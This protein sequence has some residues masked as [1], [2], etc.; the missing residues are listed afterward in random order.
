MTTGLTILRQ[1]IWEWPQ[2]EVAFVEYSDGDIAVVVRPKGEQDYATV[3]RSTR[4]AVRFVRTLID[5]PFYI[6]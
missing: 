4:E 6:T 1:T 5:L 3:C 2:G